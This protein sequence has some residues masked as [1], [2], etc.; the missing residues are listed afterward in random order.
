[1]L[2]HSIR[3]TIDEAIKLITFRVRGAPPSAEIVDTML[4]TLTS[5]REP[6]AYNQIFDYRQMTGLVDGAD[7]KRVGDFWAQMKMPPE[8]FVKVCI[9]SEDPLIQARVTGFKSLLVQADARA[10]RKMYQAL[11]WLG[12]GQSDAA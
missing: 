4:G 12:C 11:D 6:W 5:L 1:M 7:V 9:V 8:A 3:V 10:V 2:D